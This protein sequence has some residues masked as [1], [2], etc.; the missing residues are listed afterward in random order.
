MGRII[1]EGA[2]NAAEMFLAV[3][4]LTKYLTSRF[5]GAK[6]C[7][8]F[9]AG[10][11]GAFAVVSAINCITIF[12]SYG[13]YVYV[14]VYFIYALLCLNG[15]FAQ[16]LWM[17]V[18]TQIIITMTT[19]LTLVAVGCFFNCD[20]KLII[21]QF[22]L[23][24]VFAIV[25]SKLVTLAVYMAILRYRRAD[26]TGNEER[27]WYALIIVPFL[28]VISMTELMKIVLIHPDIKNKIFLGMLC[29][30]AANIIV[31]CFYMIISN[32]HRNEMTIKLLE[33]E[34]ININDRIKD[35]DM[36]IKDMRL[37][38]H[39]VKNHLM[40]V[41]ML[42]DSGKSKEA[43][44]YVSRL[45]SAYLPNMR[46]YVDTGNYGFDALVNSKII[47]CETNSVRF[48]VQPNSK[49]LAQLDPVDTGIIFGN[50][51]DNAIDAAK[52]SAEKK[53]ELAVRDIAD[54]VEIFINNSVDSAVLK[55]NPELKTTKKNKDG[56]GNGIES[57]KKIVEKYDG[58]IQFSESAPNEFGCSVMLPYAK[59]KEIREREEREE[60]MHKAHNAAV[61]ARK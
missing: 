30:C 25:I 9:I 44:D 36:F 22:G 10:W 33:Q 11:F 46:R 54:Y 50:L 43:Y 61:F 41:N 15:S 14:A 1:F 17:S 26:E 35:N 47:L 29:I 28:S 24:R 18:I 53:V 3:G 5:N 8:C 32:V 23:M 59:I 55:K 21:T 42:I 16:K 12:E 13:T 31:Y 45:L 27:L 52:E 4:F 40:T 48:D 57:V 19:V 7:L 38:K 34:N 49:Y 56:H 58:L 37:F 60:K 20:P 39:D 6:A 51:L 2:V